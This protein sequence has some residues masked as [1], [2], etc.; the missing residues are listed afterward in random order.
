M[1]EEQAKEVREDNARVPCCVCVCQYR[2]CKEKFHQIIGG[3]QIRQQ[4]QN[5]ENKK[6]VTR[7]DGESSATLRN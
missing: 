2:A 3:K 6:C 5:V 1:H 4:K 7:A